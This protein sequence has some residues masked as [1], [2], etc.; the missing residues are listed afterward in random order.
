MMLARGRDHDVFDRAIDVQV[1]RL[2]KL[3]EPD[4]ANPRYIQTVWG[5]GYVFVPDAGDS[6]DK[7]RE[8]AIRRAR[9][10]DAAAALAVR[11]PRAASRRRGRARA[12]R[13]DPAV[14]AGPHRAA[15]PPVRRHQDRA[16]AGDA[17]GARGE[18]HARAARIARPDRPRVRR[19]HRA[20]ERAPEHRRRAGAAA[21]W[22]RWQRGCAKRLGAGT[23]LRVAPRART[24]PRA[25][26]SG[27]ARGYW[28]GFP[29]PR[30]ASRGLSVARG[31]VAHDSRGRAARRRVRL[32]ALSR[33]SA[34][35]ARRRR[36]SASVAARRRRRC[37]STARRRSSTGQSRLQPDAREPAP[38]RARSRGAARRRLARPAHAARA[39]AAR[40]RDGDARRGD[41]RRDGRRHRGDGPHHRPVPR[42]RARPTT[43]RAR[44]ASDAQRRSSA[45][46]VE[47]YARAGKDVRFAPGDVPVV[48]LRPTAISR[49]VANLIDNAL[50]YGAPPVEV[51]TAPRR[52]RA[53][54]SMSPI[55][56]PA[57]RRA[58]S[59]G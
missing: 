53:S 48:P 10:S 29:L 8:R 22:S 12:R 19:A 35:P 32:R 15:R 46:C 34:A 2:R 31:A 11:P 45:A 17:R 30:A 24:P 14:P 40:R 13:D 54:C 28:V 1:S 37:P 52:R 44:E 20:G 36:S 16:A 27:A 41:A 43:M 47:R 58:T 57:S 59:S 42:L 55:A 21:R 5:F 7:R 49:L 25:R 56:V 50:A 3:V 33:A 4:P 23:E 39:A 6:G 51:T 38:D 18:R 26:R 9:R